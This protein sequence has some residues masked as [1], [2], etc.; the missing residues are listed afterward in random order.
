MAAWLHRGWERARRVLY[1]AVDA[2][3]SS[4]APPVSVLS[5]RRSLGPWTDKE[6]APGR[7]R[8]APQVVGEQG[9]G[10]SLA[11]RA[12]SVKEKP[13]SGRERK[14]GRLRPLPVRPAPPASS[15]RSGSLFLLL[16]PPLFRRGG[17]GRKPPSPP[18]HW[19]ARSFG[20]GLR[21]SDGEGAPR[22]PRLCCCARAGGGSGSRLCRLQGATGC[23]PLAELVA[24]KRRKQNGL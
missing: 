3:S 7:R 5:C 6:A 1:E 2:L 23:S 20:R 15:S 19:R 14:L 17:W 8:R 4:P 9:C 11:R 12:A 16:P 21:A 18:W 22:L 24:S 13:T 10:A